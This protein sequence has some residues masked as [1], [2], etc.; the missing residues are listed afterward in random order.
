M[1]ANPLRICYDVTTTVHHPAS[2]AQPAQPAHDYIPAGLVKDFNIGWNSAARSI[3]ELAGSGWAQFKVRATG[4]VVGLCAGSDETRWEGYTHAFAVMGD[5]LE[6]SRRSL[7]VMERGAEVLRVVG[8]AGSATVLRIERRGGRVA[9][10][11]DGELVY[12][13]SAPSTG[14]V[15]LAAALYSGGDVVFDPQLQD[16][17]DSFIDFDGRMHSLDGKL[18][19]APYADFGGRMH[20]LKGSLG[21]PG[22]LDFLGRAHPLDGKWAD[23]PYADFSGRMR[24]LEGHLSKGLRPPNRGL[25]IGRMYPPVTYLY[26]ITGGLVDVTAIAHPPVGLWADYDYGFFSGTMR[27]AQGFLADSGFAQP[28]QPMP[29]MRG[30]TLITGAQFTMA[31]RAARLS[32]VA[33]VTPADAVA[34]PRPTLALTA[35]AQAAL[36][37]PAPTLALDTTTEHVARF[38]LGAPAALLSVHAMVDG[39]AQVRMAAPA[40]TLGL[41]AGANVGMTGPAPTLQAQAT[42]EGRAQIAMGM[43]AALLS[44]VAQAE[45]TA[46]IVLAAPPTVGAAWADAVLTMPL[47][48]LR[49]QATALVPVQHEAYAVNLRTTLESGGNEVTRYTGFPFERIVRWRG[50]YWAIAAGGLYRIGSED[51]DG[52]PIEW[53]VRTGTTDFGKQERK[54]P[55]CCYVGGRMPPASRFTVYTGEKR[56][57]AYPYTTPRGATAQNYR[58]VFGKGLR[59]RYYAFEIEGAGELS[60]DNLEYLIAPSARRI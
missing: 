39:L 45:A 18:A 21:L 35:G 50:S 29:R 58:Q 56:Q 44:L 10:Y 32:M 24:P 59:E 30:L 38:T 43:P 31:P 57:D 26:T 49:L 22:R 16:T 37:G 27:P 42:V 34:L 41:A 12:R 23:A 51:D 9:Y 14:A 8:G 54:T 2:P 52:E 17:D 25:F 33:T 36:T 20:P 53:A 4:A 3:G 55:V 19:D 11:R 6:A 13:S 5:A 7:R 47:A 15:H 48:R 40:A 28:P 1:S 46:Q 60:I